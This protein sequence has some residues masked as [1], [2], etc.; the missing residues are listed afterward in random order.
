MLRT[1]AWINLV[2]QVVIAV[3]MITGYVSM[4]KNEKN[5]L[6]SLAYLCMMGAISLSSALSLGVLTW[7]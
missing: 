1:I 2:Y 3:I 4:T 6:A 5:E 7:R